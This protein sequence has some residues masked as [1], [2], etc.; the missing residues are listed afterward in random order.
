MRRGEG[1]E[2][3]LEPEV[4]ITAAAIS[5]RLARKQARQPTKTCSPKTRL[6]SRQATV[7]GGFPGFLVRRGPQRRSPT[8]ERPHDPV[9]PPTS[10]RRACGVRPAS[11][12]RRRRLS[13]RRLFF[14]PLRKLGVWRRQQRPYPVCLQRL[15]TR[16]MDRRCHRPARARADRSQRDRDAVAHGAGGHHRAAAAAR[17]PSGGPHGLAPRAAGDRRRC[18]RGRCATA[19]E[20]GRSPGPPAAQRGQPRHRGAG[21]ARAGRQ[22]RGRHGAPGLR[23]YRARAGRHLPR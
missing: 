5:T 11:P 16:R 2:K 3:G 7:A 12:S 1:P 19:A 15:R 22:A 18:H 9:R 20:P 6:R 10:G 23:P 21:R 8:Q 17:G 13:H 14:R 4:R